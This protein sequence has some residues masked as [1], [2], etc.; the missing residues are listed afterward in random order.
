MKD[1]DFSKIIVDTTVQEKDV[2]FA[3]EANHAH[4]ARQRHVRLAKKYR[5]ALRQTYERLVKR[6]LI[7]YQLYTH[8]KHFKRG[9]KLLHK[10]KS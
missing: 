3:E 4:K 10:L 5:I 2:A 6:I 9:D 1:S 8:A 7:T